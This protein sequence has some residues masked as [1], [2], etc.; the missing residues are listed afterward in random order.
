MSQSRL[1]ISRIQV[2]IFEYVWFTSDGSPTKEPTV[3]LS[4]YTSNLSGGGSKWVV[5]SGP[6]SPKAE[7]DHHCMDILHP[8]FNDIVDIAH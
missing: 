8:V 6:I 1:A 4:C 7:K 2:K 5:D 3:T